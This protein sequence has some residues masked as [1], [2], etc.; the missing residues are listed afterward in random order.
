MFK[1]IAILL[2]AIVFFVGAKNVYDQHVQHAEQLRQ[3]K[4]TELRSK[5]EHIK[6]NTVLSPGEQNIALWDIRE[7]ILLKRATFEELA[8]SKLDL[9]ATHEIVRGRCVTQYEE[10]LKDPGQLDEERKAN[11]WLLDE[12]KKE[13]YSFPLW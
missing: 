10:W 5:L 7:A 12:V 9:V 6:N 13:K 11:Q 1:I 3:T 4:L 2:F 8:T